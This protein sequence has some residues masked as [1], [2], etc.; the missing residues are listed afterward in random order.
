MKKSNIFGST[1][2]RSVNPDWFT[3]KVW[4]KEISGRIGSKEQD[5][6]HVHFPKG[7]RTKLHVHDGPQILIAV[8]GSGSLVTYEKTGRGRSKFPIKRIATTRLSR[9]DTVY[10]P[11][12]TLH[13]H[14]SISDR[15]EF[16]HIAINV[17][18][19]RS[20]KYRTD[21]FESDMKQAFEKI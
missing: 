18:S 4:M 9:G 6:Y 19:P 17:I 7:A 20:S 8:A 1:D 3:G 2:R 15:T 12:G 10:I 13:T 21:W 16:S 5:I 11:A 14:G